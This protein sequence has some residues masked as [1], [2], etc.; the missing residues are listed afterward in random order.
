MKPEIAIKD[1]G[2]NRTGVGS[3]CLQ[4]LANRLS[5]CRRNVVIIL[6]RAP[7]DA[8]TTDDVTVAVP[9]GY[10]ARKRDQST[11]GVLDVVQRAAWLRQVADFARGHVKHSGRSSLLDRNVDGPKP[12][13]VHSCEGFEVGTGIDNRDVHF[14]AQLVAP[15]KSNRY[16]QISLLERDIWHKEP[17]N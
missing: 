3:N 5:S 1:A 14:D 16:S 2:S 6:Y 11:V 12:R 9:D 10:A 8:N 15:I 4:E 13:I 7:R 17:P